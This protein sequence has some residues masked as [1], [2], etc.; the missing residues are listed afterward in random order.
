M[1]K[2]SV[3]TST[4]LQQNF[5]CI[6]LLFVSGAQTDS[7]VSVSGNQCSNAVRVKRA[8]AW[9]LHEQ[10]TFRFACRSLHDSHTFHVGFYF[11]SNWISSIYNNEFHTTRF[12]AVADPRGR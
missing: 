2:S 5:L 10:L 3:Y 6:I 8:C 4:H 11:Y 7:A 12:L 1:F 9:T